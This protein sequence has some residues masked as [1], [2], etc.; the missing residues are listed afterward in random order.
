MKIK[1]FRN[2]YLYF[3]EKFSYYYID[4]R[5]VTIVKYARKLKSQYIEGFLIII[6]LIILFNR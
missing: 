3:L 1:N 5:L 6:H 2:E 4:L